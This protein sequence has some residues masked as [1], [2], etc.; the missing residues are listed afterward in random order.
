MKVYFVYYYMDYDGDEHHGVF[1][2]KEL[3]EKDIKKYDEEQYGHSREGM[4][5]WTWQI[6]EYEL[7][8]WV[9]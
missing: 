4:S 8:K 6:T 3:A 2:S 5:G 7:D 1:S 9:D